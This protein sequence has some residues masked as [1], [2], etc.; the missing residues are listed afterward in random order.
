ME[1]IIKNIDPLYKV[2]AFR[3]GGLLLEPFAKL[4]DA[5]IKNEIY[6]DS[7]VSPGMTYKHGDFSFDFRNYP[8][9]PN[10]KFNHSPR[11]IEESGH[12]LEVPISSVKIPFTLNIYYKILRRIKYS[13]LKSATKGEAVFQSFHQQSL[14][15]RVL[16]TLFKRNYS[17]YTIDN[18]FKERYEYIFRKIPRI[19]NY[20]ITSKGIKYSY[21]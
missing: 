5:M 21:R 7:S 17:L 2:R 16:N 10:Y 18:N 15:I 14:F 1:D 3:A 6:I 20:D 8:R 11:F 19:W 12:F 4:K 9:R 13:H